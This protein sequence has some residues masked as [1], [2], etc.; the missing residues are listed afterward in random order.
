MFV[1]ES[2]MTTER[3]GEGRKNGKKGKAEEKEKGK[4]T[5]QVLEVLLLHLVGKLLP[6]SILDV[7][8]DLVNVTLVTTRLDVGTLILLAV[9]VGGGECGVGKG[10]RCGVDAV[11]V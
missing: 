3:R 11:G 6:T 9:N 7:V 2:T 10:A 4:R 5:G 1:V 8:V